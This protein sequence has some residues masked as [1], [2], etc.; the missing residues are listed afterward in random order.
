MVTEVIY[1]VYTVGNNMALPGPAMQSTAEFVEEELKEEMIEEP[2]ESER[3]A[4]SA[5]SE[6]KSADKADKKVRFEPLR[7]DLPPELQE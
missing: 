4:Y 5:A 3:S 2:D 7:G 1:S 6:D